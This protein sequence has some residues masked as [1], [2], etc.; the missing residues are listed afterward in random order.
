MYPIGQIKL[1]WINPDNYNNLESNFF[2]SIP[3]AIT[4]AQ[5]RKDWLIFK[6]K[7]NEGNFYSWELLPYGAHRK[8]VNGMK[9]RDNMGLIVS[10]IVILFVVSIYST[11][12][13]AKR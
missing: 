5:G 10:G 7:N 11:Y 3:E 2:A 8:Y 1:T 4:Y 9:A 13:I 12:L 6:L